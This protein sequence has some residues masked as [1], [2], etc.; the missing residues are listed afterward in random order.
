MKEPMASE[1]PSKAEYY[2]KMSKLIKKDL[3]NIFRI[4]KRIIIKYWCSDK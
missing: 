1:P 3:K 2:S 4:T